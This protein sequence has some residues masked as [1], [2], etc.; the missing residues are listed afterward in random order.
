MWNDTN[1]GKG[2]DKINENIAGETRTKTTRRIRTT[3]AEHR[4]RMLSRKRSRK[5]QGLYARWTM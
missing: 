5:R 1:S 3:D 2:Q 4:I